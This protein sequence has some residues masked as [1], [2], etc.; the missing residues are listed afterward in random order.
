[1][2]FNA[3]EWL[4]IYNKVQFLGNIIKN[5]CEHVDTKGEWTLPLYPISSQSNTSIENE[6]KELLTKNNHYL[7][8]C[9]L[10]PNPKLWEFNIK[11]QRTWASSKAFK[12]KKLINS[13]K[14]TSTYGLKLSIKCI[15]S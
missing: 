7:N 15:E 11:D 9:N 3:N 8:A 2:Q 6:I 14:Y 5:S 10:F 1:M 12:Y 4:K 13:C